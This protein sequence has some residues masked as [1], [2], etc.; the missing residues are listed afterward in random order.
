MADGERNAEREQEE[1]VEI[2]ASWVGLE[3][4][5]VHPANT[6]L[7]Q[8]YKDSFYLSFGLFVPPPLLGSD[9]ERLAQV[10]E[11][12]VLPISPVAR[13]SMTRPA[14]ERLIAILQEN[15]QK[16]DAAQEAEEG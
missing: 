12:G 4:Q 15:L 14:L 3:E 11:L 7:S 1:Q 2:R 10:R 16:F 5:E 9:E 8:F 6:F 13:V